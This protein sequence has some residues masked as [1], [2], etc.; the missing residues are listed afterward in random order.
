LDSMIEKEIDASLQEVKA[1]SDDTE[2][3]QVELIESPDVKSYDRVIFAS[4]VHAFCLSKVMRTYLSE[5][6]SLA[7]KEVILFV[8][9]HFPFA[10][11]GG[12]SALR[13]M[14]Q[15]VLSK[16]GKVKAMFSI[17]W[18]SKKRELGIQKMIEQVLQ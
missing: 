7:N 5:I 12:N 16:D 18:S 2:Q 14:S 4:P 6:D 15:K 17:N 8:T 10:W 9:H 13:Q 1:V 11:M 3:K